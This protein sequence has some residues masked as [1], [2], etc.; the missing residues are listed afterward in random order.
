MPL[1]T[2]VEG[3][4]NLPENKGECRVSDLQ[5]QHAPPELT[6]LPEDYGLGI[7]VLECK[8]ILGLDHYPQLVDG[9]VLCNL[10]QEGTIELFK[11]LANSGILFP[12]L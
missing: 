8:I 4:G 3:N 6:H 12:G 5:H 10:D 1:N 7:N 11:H 2:F 9:L